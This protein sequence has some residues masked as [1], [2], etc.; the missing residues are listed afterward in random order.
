MCSLSL[1]RQNEIIKENGIIKWN[2]KVYYNF[3]IQHKKGNIFPITI[4]MK[5]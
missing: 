5:S 4:S 2:N 3:I 1:I